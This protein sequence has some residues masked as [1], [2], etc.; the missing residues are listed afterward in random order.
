MIET[1]NDGPVLLQS[2]L[3]PS[4]IT[5]RNLDGGVENTNGYLHDL[6]DVGRPST[7]VSEPSTETNTGGP[8][9]PLTNGFDTDHGLEEHS[10]DEYTVIQ[11][12]PTLF[13]TV[14]VPSR[15]DLNEGRTVAMR[16]ERVGRQFQREWLREQVLEREQ[17]PRERSADGN[18]DG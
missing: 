11:P 15:S 18:D 1:S 3:N 7:G 4:S 14:V 6:L 13:G 16:M 9:H 8:S 5:S 2:Y 12:P 17:A 10:G